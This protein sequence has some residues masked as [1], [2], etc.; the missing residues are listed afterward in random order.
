MEGSRSFRACSAGAILLA[1]ALAL[2]GAMRSGA[3]QTATEAP[4][5]EALRQLVELMIANTHRND[6][7]IEDYQRIEHWTERKNEKDPQV[8]FDKTYRVVPTG[9]GTLRVI[10]KENGNAVTPE[11]YRNELRQLAEVLE[12]ALDPNEQKQKARVEKWKRRTADRYQAVEAFRDAYTVTWLGRETREGRALVKLKF[13]PKPEYHAHSVGTDLLSNS[14]V[15]VWLDGDAQVVR[16]EAEL[17]RDM[18]FGG[19]LLGKIY[20]GGRVTIDQFEVSPGLWM[21]RSTRYEVRG[22]K[23]LFFAEQW[24]AGEANDYRW[25]GPPREALEIVRSE[26][27][28][29]EHS[30]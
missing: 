15:T 12:W 28:K 20:K 10:L 4:S 5:P 26:L 23:F 24:R 7:A 19:G 9:T 25:V 2:G 8:R 14:R 17:V 1:T 29:L 27:S 3:A 22:R 21:P 30:S 16:L 6:A 18:A 11:Y 13:E